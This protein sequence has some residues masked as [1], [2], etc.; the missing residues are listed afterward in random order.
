VPY[1][2][3]MID[4]KVVG[5][6]LAIGLVLLYAFGSGFFMDNSGWYQGL[7]KPSWQPP[8]AIFGV[9]WPYNF[10]MLGVSGV[11]VVR[12]SSGLQSILFLVF[13]ALS[14]TAAITWSYYFYQPHNFFAAS[15]S[16]VLATL[17][18]LP[19]LIITFQINTLLGFLLIPYQIWLTIATVL[20]FSYGRLN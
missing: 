7:K 12:N 14:V 5:I 18:T 19:I 4:A 6:A 20:S 15:L 1:P 9:I 13:L 16:L 3:N 17:L 11:A 2:C 8:G 10:I